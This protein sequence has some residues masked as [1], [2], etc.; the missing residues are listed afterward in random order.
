MKKTYLFLTMFLAVGLTACGGDSK[1]GTKSSETTEVAKD[2][3]KAN[4]DK[5]EEDSEFAEEENSEYT[6]EEETTEYTE[7]EE[8]T[9]TAEN[10]VEAFLDEY[11]DY[12]DQ[13]IVTAKK[14]KDG[15]MDMAVMADLANL[16]QKAADIAEKCEKAK[17][18]MTEKQ[19]KRLMNIADKLAKAAQG[20]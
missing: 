1:E 2:G 16:S 13:Y 20:L 19:A 17:D 4:D 18:D 6:E 10:D 7:E 8:A 3:E 11:E 14:V 15:N 12:V 5:N 9:E